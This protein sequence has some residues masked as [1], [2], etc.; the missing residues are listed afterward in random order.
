MAI[1]EIKKF[2]LTL[3]YSKGKFGIGFEH[4]ETDKPGLLV[5]SALE[6]MAIADLLRN[7]Q[8][9]TYDE[10]TKTIGTNFRPLGEAMKEWPDLNK[11]EAVV[12]TGS[13]SGIEAVLNEIYRSGTP[14]Q[15][16]AILFSRA[17]VE[18]TDAERNQI[19]AGLESGVLTEE[20]ARQKIEEIARSRG[21]A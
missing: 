18:P 3:D 20:Q 11:S 13:S 15:R 8:H 12:S 9:A 4:S 5:G 14:E 10:E 21:G 6:A 7:S 17:G 2:A 16:V 19:I 1:K